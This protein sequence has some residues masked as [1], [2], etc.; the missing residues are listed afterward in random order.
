MQKREPCGGDVAML[1]LYVERMHT[2]RSCW[3][4]TTNPGHNSVPLFIKFLYQI[5]SRV[6]KDLSPQPR[7]GST[8]ASQNRAS[9]GPRAAL[10]KISLRLRPAALWY[11]QPNSREERDF[12]G[13]SFAA[14]EHFPSAGPH[15]LL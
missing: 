7:G 5:S 3:K 12:Y 8:P 13:L 6:T 14:N 10:H 1:R 11:Y 4:L 9:W 15:L 2:K